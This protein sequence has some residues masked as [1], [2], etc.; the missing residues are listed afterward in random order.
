MDTA[1]QPDPSLTC[2]RCGKPAAKQWVCVPAS[3]RDSL[4]KQLSP[5]TATLYK[6]ECGYVWA[7][8]DSDPDEENS[9]PA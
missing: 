7:V 1:P 4:A 8:Y 3:V 6:C 2:L 9:R 5:A